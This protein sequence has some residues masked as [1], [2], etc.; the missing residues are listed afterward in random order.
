MIFVGMDSLQA[1]LITRDS[2]KPGAVRRLL[3]AQ[4]SLILTW[5]RDAVF[6]EYRILLHNFII[7]SHTSSTESNA[8]SVPEITAHTVV[9]TSSTG[10]LG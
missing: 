7:D 9:L 3:S 6:Q 8:R 10:A 1:L 5:P 4:Y 2:E